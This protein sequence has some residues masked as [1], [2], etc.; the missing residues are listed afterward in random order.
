MLN[1]NNKNCLWKIKYYQEKASFK[2]KNSLKKLFI[3]KN[4]Q[5]IKIF[6]FKVKNDIIFQLKKDY[7][8]QYLAINKLKSS[9]YIKK[10]NI[11]IILR[12]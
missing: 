2:Q 3:N 11:I 9:F 7:I 1:K 10:M 4:H 8:I 6:K 5:T 12:C